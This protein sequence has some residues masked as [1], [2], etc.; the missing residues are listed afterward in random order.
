MAVELEIAGCSVV[1]LGQ[2]NPAIFH[3]S[4]LLLHG[5]ISEGQAEESEVKVIHPDIAHMVIGTVTLT[6]EQ[7]RCS[8]ATSSAPLIRTADFAVQMFG[9]LLTHTP[10]SQAGINTQRHYRLPSAE[11]RHEFGRR[12]APTEA[13]GEW[14]DRLERPRKKDSRNGVQIIAMREYWSDTPWAGWIQTKVE[15]S[16]RI[17][18]NL[19][20]SIEKNH[21]IA[22]EPSANRVAGPDLVQYIAKSFDDVI[23]DSD[24]IERQLFAGI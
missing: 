10:I 9:K 3:P 11:V 22:A 4:W 19:G 6:V 24:Y 12:L 8:I 15:P 7:Q 14:G 20:V 2:F 18:H 23:A 5:L 17:G 13:W 1:L 16:T 21:H